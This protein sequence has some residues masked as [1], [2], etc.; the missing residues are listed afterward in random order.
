MKKFA[1]ITILLLTCPLMIYSQQVSQKDATKAAVNELKGL[2]KNTDVKVK[3]VI[4]W[5]KGKNTLMYEVMTYDGTSVLVSGH[6]ACMP[7]LATSN[8]QGHSILKEY[9]SLPC[10]M[11]FMLDWYAI[12]LDRC[13]SRDNTKNAYHPQWKSLLKAAPNYSKSDYVLPL[14]QTKWKQSMSNDGNEKY[15]YN[16]LIDNPWYISDD[17]CK[18]PKAGCGA[19]AMAQVMKYYNYPVIQSG[20]LQQYDWCDMPNELRKNGSEYGVEDYERKKLA[21]ARLMADCADKV[22]IPGGYGCERTNSTLYQI[23]DALSDEYGYSNRA[24]V[25]RQNNHSETWWTGELKSE[26]RQGHP[27]IYAGAKNMLGSDSHIFICDGFDQSDRFH[28]NWGWGE[29]WS[30]CYWS[31]NYIIDTTI[32][33]GDPYDWYLMALF[34]IYPDCEQDVCNAYMP[35]DL[36][37]SSITPPPTNAMA[38]FYAPTT[39]ATLISASVNSTHEWRTIPSGL[40]GVYQAHKEVILQDGFEAEYGCEFEARI[41]PCALCD[42]QK[43]GTKGGQSAPADYY[44]EESPD[45]L[46]ISV[47]NDMVVSQYTDNAELFPNPTDGPLTMSV[48]GSAERMVILNMMGQP[49]GGWHIVSLSET[50][51]TLDVSSLRPGPYMISVVTPN[52]PQTARFIRR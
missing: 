22:T 47:V 23:E 20:L 12:Q 33:N 21:V 36:Y 37:Y 30:N 5:G 16:C 42:E 8:G 13:F 26:L 3:D 50:P 6:Y 11:Q 46:D 40:L 31:V 14:I 19:V 24:E 35:L 41:V 4:S 34:Y 39:M 48:N 28:F 9:D 10:G 2:R 52:G 7:I 18:H 27:V 17:N 32:D 44:M 25:I 38:S 29:N 1:F 43:N 45:T 15:A 51:V 49:I